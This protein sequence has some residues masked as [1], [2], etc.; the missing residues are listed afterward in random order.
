MRLFNGIVKKESFNEKNFN[1]NNIIKEI[2]ENKEEKCPGWDFFRISRPMEPL[3]T[4]DGKYSF[5]YNFFEDN[6]F[7]IQ[8][9]KENGKDSVVCSKQFDTIICDFIA[10]YTDLINKEIRLKGNPFSEYKNTVES[11]YQ[12]VREI[13]ITEK[14]IDFENEQIYKRITASS[15]KELFIKL[16][17][18]V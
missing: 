3:I 7:F 4:P 9:G 1:R 12:I 11:V 10:I 14:D 6:F 15:A 5:I 2:L 18:E 8:N 17:N 16:K 13:Y